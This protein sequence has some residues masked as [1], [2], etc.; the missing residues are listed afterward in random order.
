MEYVLLLFD[1]KRDKCRGGG[2]ANDIDDKCPRGGG[3][4]DY[5]NPCEY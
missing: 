4:G 1:I 5:R 3:G 2:E